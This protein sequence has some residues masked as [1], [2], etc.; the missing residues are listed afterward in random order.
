MPDIRPTVRLTEHGDLIAA[1]PHLLGFYPGRSLVVIA[2]APQANET[3][4]IAACLRSDLP[5]EHNPQLPE[6]AALLARPLRHI[7]ASHAV[8]LVVSGPGGQVM[9]SPPDRPGVRTVSTVLEDAGICVSHTLWTHEIKAGQPWACYES[10]GCAGR[11]LS[12]RTELT[13]QPRTP[14]G[15]TAR[16]LSR[17][18][19]HCAVWPRLRTMGMLVT[20]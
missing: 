20:G 4:T 5:S 18:A 12:P 15:P 17:P 16:R 8:L 10:D 6:L 19:T 14:P 1:V 13:C 7:G 3:L 11:K 9:D 2:I